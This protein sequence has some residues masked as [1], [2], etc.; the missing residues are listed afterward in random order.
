MNYMNPFSAIDPSQ[1]GSGA[2]VSQA[3]MAG[4]KAT[5]AQPFIDMAQQSQGIDLATALQKFKEMMDPASVEARMSEQQLKGATNKANMELLP[6]QTAAAKAKAISDLELQPYM[7][8]QKR[9]EAIQAAREA[10]GKPAAALFAMGSE[11]YEAIEKVPEP[12]RPIAYQQMLE[13]WKAQNPGAPIPKGMET[14]TPKTMQGLGMMRYGQLNSV[15]HQQGMAKQEADNAAAYTRT[16]DSTKMAGEFGLQRERIQQAGADRRKSMDDSK[17]KALKETIPNAI[18]RT[19]R[20][21]ASSKDPEEIARATQELSSH[22]AEPIEKL[23]NQNEEYKALANAKSFSQGARKEALEKEI[24]KVRNRIK[25]DVYLQSGVAQEKKVEG[26][27]LVIYGTRFYDRGN[28]MVGN[29]D[30]TKLK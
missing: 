18:A 5:A 19:K 24:Q 8:E 14:Y 13:R 29:I 4:A 15:G 2:T 1:L 10:Q 3:A 9:E 11:M 21:L 30:I 23:T 25:F 12:M 6:H 28:G 22:L 7:T 26:R 17:E 20:V 16:M 27:D